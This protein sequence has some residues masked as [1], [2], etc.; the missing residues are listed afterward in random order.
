MN[1][2]KLCMN[3]Q[4]GILYVDLKSKMT[5]KV[6][7]SRRMVDAMRLY[8][9]I[10]NYFFLMNHRHERTQI[11]FEV[12]LDGLV[13]VWIQNDNYHMTFIFI[14]LFTKDPFP[15]PGSTK[16]ICH[17]IRMIIMWAMHTLVSLWLQYTRD[18][19]TNYIPFYLYQYFNLHR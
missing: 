13:Q 7:L 5:A 14:Y 11:V 18:N 3:G 1:E 8:N 16:I 19:Y 6:W 15:Q 12:S 4:E 2:L 17:L 10:N 9:Q